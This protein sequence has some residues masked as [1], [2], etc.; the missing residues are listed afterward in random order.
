[1]D[2][3][4][5]TDEAANE[6]GFTDWR[7]MPVED[8]LRL[9]AGDYGAAFN[10]EDLVTSE[11]VA[12]PL[13][14]YRGEAL[15]VTRIAFETTDGQQRYIYGPPRTMKLFQDRMGTVKQIAG[16]SLAMFFNRMLAMDNPDNPPIVIP[17]CRD[18]AAYVC[19]STMH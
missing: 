17:G 19:G 12:P 4:R 16:E 9:L 2:D 13:P 7:P 18:A 5:T 1:M 3:T 14:G 10:P 6:A 15:P 11:L 8:L